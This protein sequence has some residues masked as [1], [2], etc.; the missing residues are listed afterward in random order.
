MQHRG[1]FANNYTKYT[2]ITAIANEILFLFI[3]WLFIS[4]SL[5][6]TKSQMLR[7]S[8]SRGR[9]I[10]ETYDRVHYI[11]SLRKKSEDPP[12]QEDKTWKV[13]LCKLD[14]EMSIVIMITKDGMIDAQTGALF[15]KAENIETTYLG[16][17]IE[18][19]LHHEVDTHSVLFTVVLQRAIY[20][21]KCRSPSERQQ[22][23]LTLLHHL[24]ERGGMN[25]KKESSP[26]SPSTQQISEQIRE[27]KQIAPQD[28]S[29]RSEVSE[30]TL[31]D[32]DD[33]IQEEML[34]MESAEILRPI[35]QTSNDQEIKSKNDLQ[36]TLLGAKEDDTVS[37]LIN[38][39]QSR[40]NTLLEQDRHLETLSVE[41]AKAE[42]EKHFKTTDDLLLTLLAKKGGLE[43]Q[44]EAID[45]RHL[46]WKLVA[47]EAI[48]ALS[49]EFAYVWIT[50]TS[51]LWETVIFAFSMSFGY[52]WMAYR[53]RKS[54]TSL[55]ILLLIL[56]FT[57]SI[58][59]GALF[60]IG[61]LDLW[62]KVPLV[63]SHWSD[64]IS[65]YM[66]TTYQE[67]QVNVMDSDTDPII[68]SNEQIDDD[69]CTMCTCWGHSIPNVLFGMVSAFISYQFV[70]VLQ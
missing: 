42:L 5:K 62:V 63:W 35:P 51:L 44:E 57:S 29:G 4:T 12:F 56:W 32:L 66:V 18:S 2:S 38:R 6:V 46:R 70:L 19:L 60:S 16:P 39:M 55:F 64:I 52:I 67:F 50:M 24:R 30:G 11:H 33:D 47:S 27:D 49:E 45:R 41:N 21:F 15:I 36:P 22:I 28:T 7:V 43:E 13:K 17:S 14:E 37:D 54:I 58:W 53:E 61:N 68:E 20:E 1:G 23:V 65:D 8:T 59:Y 3:P 69:I 48:V 10:V 25:K 40:M 9:P 26:S 34:Q 31:E